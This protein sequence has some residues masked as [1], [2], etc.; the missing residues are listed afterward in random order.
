MSDAVILARSIAG[1]A[2]TNVAGRVQPSE[3]Q[4]NQLDKA[5]DDNTWHDTPDLSRDNLK[6]QARSQFNKQKPAGTED[7]KDAVADA[8]R[9]A[10]QQPTAD[11]QDQAKVGASAAAGTLKD[12]ASANVPEDTKQRG[13]E[14]MNN[15]K[16]YLGDKMPRE[17]REQTI[18]RL[19]KMV[20]EVQG[21]QDCEHPNPDYLCKTN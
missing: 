8:D 1:D 17:R 18:W 6:S 3:D 10:Q 11:G 5:A 20:V 7:V 4:L 13:R 16:S 14:T 2:A 19:K 12:R 21:H 9:N 15:T